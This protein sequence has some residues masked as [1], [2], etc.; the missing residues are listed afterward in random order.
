MTCPCE[1]GLR[2]RACCRRSNGSWYKDPEPFEP[3]S[4]VTGFSHPD[5]YLNVTQNCSQKIT[6]E[7]SISETALESIHTV[8]KVSGVPWLLAPKDIPVR[9]LT[10]NILCERH[11]STFSPI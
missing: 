2:P 9:S 4:P 6:G 7:H 3:P 11:N 8:V 5:C 10:S 1:S